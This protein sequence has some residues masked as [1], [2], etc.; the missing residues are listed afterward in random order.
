MTL[1]QPVPARVADLPLVDADGR[2]F[3]LA[4]LHGR[5]VVLVDFLTLC[6]EVCPLTSV[7]VEQAAR[8]LR[9]DGLGG[10]VVFVEATVDPARDT[11]ARLAAYRKLFPPNADWR[12]ATGSPKDLTALWTWFGVGYDRVAEQGAAKGTPPKDWL[13]GTP[14]AYDVEHQDVVWVLGPDGHQR[15]EENGTPDAH[16]QAP[17]ATLEHFLSDQGR[18]K[19]AHPGADSWSADDVVAAV[20]YVEGS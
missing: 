2:T 10:K 13:T 12:L 7:D 20:R 18:Q 1:D 16:G 3:T 19:L 14:L 11:V 6:Q 4:S 17:P 8:A 9:A 5:T 15:W